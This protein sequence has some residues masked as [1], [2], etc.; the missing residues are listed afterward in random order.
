LQIK[1]AIKS[2]NKLQINFEISNERIKPPPKTPT[3]CKWLNK[4]L[5]EEVMGH[6]KEHCKKGSRG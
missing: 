5:N 2:T 6:E 3:N 1:G 4:L